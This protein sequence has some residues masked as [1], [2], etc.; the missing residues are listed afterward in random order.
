MEAKSYVLQGEELEQEQWV[1]Q[2]WNWTCAL[3]KNAAK[4]S[5]VVSHLWLSWTTYWVSKVKIHYLYKPERCH[6]DIAMHVCAI[7]T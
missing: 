4:L 5:W 6:E 2:Y 7:P 1:K 3:W